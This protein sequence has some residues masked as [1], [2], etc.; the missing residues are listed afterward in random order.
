MSIYDIVMET[1]ET[2]KPDMET[3]E[4]NMLV[5]LKSM[6]DSLE[7]NI[8]NVKRAL[9]HFKPEGERTYQNPASVEEVRDTVGYLINDFWSY[10]KERQ[11]GTYSEILDVEFQDLSDFLQEDDTHKL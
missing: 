5:A 11:Y 4:S 2:T 3:V 7:Y 10:P 1:V 8:L 6:L 9:D